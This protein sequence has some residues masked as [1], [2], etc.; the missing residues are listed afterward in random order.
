MRK[1]KVLL[2]RGLIG[3]RQHSGRA[4]HISLGQFQAG[5]KHLTDNES[6]NH[7]I[8]LPR[9]VEAL[10]PVLLGGLQ[11]VPFVEHTG[12]AKMRFA[13]NLQRLITCQLQDAPVGLGRQVE[14]VV[15]FLYVAQA[16]RRQDGGEDIPGCLAESMASVKARR[17]AARS[18]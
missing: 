16:D 9:Q 1:H 12:Q 5:E 4:G 11:V 7:A 13:D 14:L 15:C 8:I 3:L 10:L 18:P 6:V 17:A 2:A